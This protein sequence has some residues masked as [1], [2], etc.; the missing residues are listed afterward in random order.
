MPHD[1]NVAVNLLFKDHRNALIRSVD[2][3]GQCSLTFIET[4]PGGQGLAETENGFKI[5]GIKS[6][7]ALRALLCKYALARLSPSTDFTVVD[8][9][10]PTTTRF[11]AEFVIEKVS[12]RGDLFSAWRALSL[13]HG[14]LI[15]ETPPEHKTCADFERGDRVKVLLD[16]VKT[17][18]ISTTLKAGSFGTVTLNVCRKNALVV[19]CKLISFCR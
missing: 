13:H 3:H 6:S 19:T 9:E 10:I 11:I 4:L 12:D 15:E 14:V 7:E 18:P 16:K 2:D 1:V 5:D 8:G 17:K